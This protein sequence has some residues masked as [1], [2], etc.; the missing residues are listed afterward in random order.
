MAQFVVHALKGLARRARVTLA[1]SPASH[2]KQC[3]RR[4]RSTREAS[5]AFERT[6]KSQKHY[7]FSMGPKLGYPTVV[8]AP[9][10]AT[11]MQFNFR[12]H[13]RVYIIQGG[14]NLTIAAVVTA[15]V[16]RG[17]HVLDPLKNICYVFCNLSVREKD[18][19]SHARGAKAT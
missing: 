2:C 11:P 19:R 13:S 17:T 14:A 7:I 1:S 9:L 16:P 10:A 5:Q 15:H 6:Q 4:L 8:S 3:S 12:D 18:W